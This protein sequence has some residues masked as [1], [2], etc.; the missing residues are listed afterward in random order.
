M[1]ET[2]QQRRL[3]PYNTE[4]ISIHLSNIPHGETFRNSQRNQQSCYD[5]W[6]RMNLTG[7]FPFHRVPMTNTRVSAA[8]SSKNEQESHEHLFVFQN[9]D[10]CK[11]HSCDSTKDATEMPQR[12]ASTSNPVLI[13]CPR[14]VLSR[15]ANVAS[16]CPKREKFLPD[17]PIAIP[18]LQN[19]RTVLDNSMPIIVP[20]STYAKE[21]SPP[22]TSCC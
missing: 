11:Q 18:P 3:N 19:D 8:S 12:Q 4:W 2:Y 16:I 7:R 1:K 14:E 5:S 6:L 22:T 17:P 10:S 21:P 15:K 13:C 9:A 20:A